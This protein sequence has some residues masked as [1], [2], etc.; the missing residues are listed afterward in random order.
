M[1]SEQESQNKR[2]S[3]VLVLRCFK[4][5]IMKHFDVKAIYSTKILYFDVN[6]G[7][8]KWFDIGIVYIWFDGL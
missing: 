6:P 3:S 1:I 2:N 8:V 5:C 7:I 4:H